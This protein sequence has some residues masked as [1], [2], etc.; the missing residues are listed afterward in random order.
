MKKT[1]LLI[2]GGWFAKGLGDILEIPGG[3]PSAQ[4]IRN[5][6]V[7]VVESDEDLFRIFYYDSDPCGQ[8]VFN[9]VDGSK[10]DFKTTRGFV[11]RRQFLFE[12]GQLPFLAL[13]RGE[14][15]ARGWEF[16]E[17][18]K[19]LLMK[20]GA[21]NPPQPRDVFPSIQQKGVDMRI[22]MD[23][24]T[25]ALKK[26]VERII[27]FSGDTDMIPAMKLARREGLQVFVTKLDPWPL[28]HNLI[29]DSD[30][31]RVLTPKP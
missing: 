9:P 15:V 13:R 20:G 1:A 23:V 28:K 12:L 10:L 4:Q 30:G 8:T 16:T 29:E 18:Y 2:D 26:L 11:A 31:V 17:A 3:W 14:A 7:S 6:A 5:N 24:A 25:L 27:L 22:G 19:A 21:Q